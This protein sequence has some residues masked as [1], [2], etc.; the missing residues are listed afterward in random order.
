MDTQWTVKRNWMKCSDCAVRLK[1]RFSSRRAHIYFTWI[2]IH[3]VEKSVRNA[4]PCTQQTHKNCNNACT[5]DNLNTL[6]WMHNAPTLFLSVMPKKLE[7]PKAS[8]LSAC[9]QSTSLSFPSIPLLSAKSFKSQSFHSQ[10]FYQAAND[11]EP[12]HS[13]HTHIPICST[14]LFGNLSSR[15]TATEIL[16]HS[17]PQTELSL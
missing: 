1:R 2:T 5:H 13:L 9:I 12:S 3:N 14:R 7:D 10:P 16:V 8:F 17:D 15:L 4:L 6:S 11:K